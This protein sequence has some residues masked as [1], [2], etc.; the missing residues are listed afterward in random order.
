MYDV[1]ELTGVEDDVSSMVGS[2]EREKGVLVDDLRWQG[3]LLTAC[4]CI[5]IVHVAQCPVHTC[6][7]EGHCVIRALI[8]SMYRFCVCVLLRAAVHT[9]LFPVNSMH[10]CFSDKHSAC[11]QSFNPITA[12][13]RIPQLNAGH[14]TC[15]SETLY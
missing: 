8:Y 10:R 15:S 7:G 11:I 6:R 4:T 3:H 13:C 1:R 2:L 9:M 12:T 14:S 5:Y